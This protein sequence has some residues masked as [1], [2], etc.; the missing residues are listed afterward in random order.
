MKN[1]KCPGRGRA[2]THRFTLDEEYPI[3]RRL[4]RQLNGR[5]YDKNQA[6]R[7]C[8]KHV[9]DEQVEFGYSIETIGCGCFMTEGCDKQN[10]CNIEMP[11]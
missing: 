10:V 7:F 9:L 2:C 4:L 6:A 11:D 3:C 1:E 5:L 8:R